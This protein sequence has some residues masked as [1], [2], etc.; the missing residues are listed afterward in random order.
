MKDITLTK[1]LGEQWV[2]DLKSGEYTQGALRY[3]TST[4]HCCLAVLEESAKKLHGERVGDGMDILRHTGMEET[5]LK[6][7]DINDGVG[8]DG[9]YT[10]VLPTIE[11][12]VKT[13]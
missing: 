2:K 1:E 4:K 12:L 3:I 11:E 10:N 13:L 9:K 5:S 6:L 7:I 8:F